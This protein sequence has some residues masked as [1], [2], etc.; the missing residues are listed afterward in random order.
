[1]IKKEE[2]TVITIY[3]N[4]IK[5]CLLPEERNE[6]KNALNKIKASLTKKINSNKNIFDPLLIRKEI[7]I[8]IDINSRLTKNNKTLFHFHNSLTKVET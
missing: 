5:E 7:K 6:E 1:M 3:Q 8:K 2:Y 4:I